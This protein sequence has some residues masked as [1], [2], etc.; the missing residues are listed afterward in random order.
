MNRFSRTWPDRGRKAAWRMLQGAG[1]VVVW[2]MVAGCAA[3]GAGCLDALGERSADTVAITVL[4]D[5]LEVM[6]RVEVHWWPSDS[7][8]LAVR[9]AW[10]GTLEG[11]SIT[12]GDG[13][14]RIEDRNTCGWVR[15]LDA[16]PRV[17]LHG[18]APSEVWLESHADFVMES[19]YSEGDLFVEGDE[20]SGHLHLHFSGDSL[21]LRLPNGIGHA[22]VKGSALRFSTFRSGF[23]DL[24]ATG[25]DADRVLAHHAGV[26]AMRLRPESYLYLELSGA[27]QV[28]LYG[29][30][31]QR[32]IVIG[33][34]AT[35]EIIDHP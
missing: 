24:D 26:G 4:P 14:L 5:R 10:Q 6:D 9:H 1:C 11:L 25:L 12:E 8:A 31:D 7:A 15:R 17:D 32:D 33:P 20:M 2:G 29:D 30:S 22:S 34:D 28:H 18:I 13:V 23:G 3:E 35:G 19:A 16:V 27:G 21:K